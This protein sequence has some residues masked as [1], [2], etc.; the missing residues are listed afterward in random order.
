MED[1][2]PTGK[3][4]NQKVW[5]WVL[6]PCLIWG[7]DPNCGDSFGLFEPGRVFDSSA[8]SGGI[9]TSVAD[10]GAVAPLPIVMVQMGPEQQSWR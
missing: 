4:P 5:V 1:P 2:Y 10:A 8:R 6:F 7:I 9:A 3:Y